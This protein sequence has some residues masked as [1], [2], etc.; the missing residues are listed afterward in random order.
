MA[1][2]AVFVEP[3]D[4]IEVDELMMIGRSG[5]RIAVWLGDVSIHLT[6]TQARTLSNE[7]NGVLEAL[8]GT[9]NA[10]AATVA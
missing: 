1:R 10:T 9:K 7:I 6:E 3:G 5:E 8:T 4:R 2:M